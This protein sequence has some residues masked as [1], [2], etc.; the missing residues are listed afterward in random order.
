MFGEKEV[1]VREFMMGESNS[2]SD[3][4]RTGCGVGFREIVWW[5]EK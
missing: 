4:L 3:L 5:C 2:V 1:D